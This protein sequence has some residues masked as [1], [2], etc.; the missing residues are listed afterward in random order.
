MVR[1]AEI[2]QSQTQTSIIP[3]TSSIMKRPAPSLAGRFF[4]DMPGLW[5]CFFNEKC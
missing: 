4:L 5:L 2:D 3:I 1:A